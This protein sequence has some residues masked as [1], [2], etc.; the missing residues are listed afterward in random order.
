M[1]TLKLVKGISYTGTVRATAKNPFCTVDTDKEAE[2]LVASGFF[3]IIFTTEVE[4]KKDTSSQKPPEEK[5][6]VIDKMKK[7]DLEA[8]AAKLGVD[9]STC[10]NNDERKAALKA[11]LEDQGGQDPAFT[12][13]VEGATP[14]EL[15]G[16]TVDQ[17]KDYAKA[18]EIDVS[19]CNDKA[20]YMTVISMALGGSL[21]I[22][23]L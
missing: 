22:M 20:D 6:I 4:C 7:E 14:E 2:A 16:M 8:L 3:K 10:K 5:E 13:K 19:S 15:E 9:L 1:I 21:T 12:L 17:L 18:H 11:V 23:G